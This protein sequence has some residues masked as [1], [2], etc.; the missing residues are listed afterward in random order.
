M[1]MQQMIQAAQKAQRMYSKE[2]EVLE[3][4]DFEGVAN[5][6]LKVVLKGNCTL[7]NI[8]IIDKD[9]LQDEESLVELIKLAY[10][11]CIDQI[12]DAEDKLQK[13]YQS[14]TGLF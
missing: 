1:N 10:Q 12:S 2:H 7:V 13:K 11:K 5:G 3:Q 6:A 9:L 14:N 4:T 8:E